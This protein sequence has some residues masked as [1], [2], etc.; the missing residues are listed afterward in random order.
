MTEFMKYIVLAPTY[1]VL[2]DKDGADKPPVIIS[3]D[4]CTNDVFQTLLLEFTLV[5][6]KMLFADCVEKM[7]YVFCQLEDKD[8]ISVP[9]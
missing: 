2:V 8:F 7:V 6:I 1:R 5:Y 9:W 3:P 4:K